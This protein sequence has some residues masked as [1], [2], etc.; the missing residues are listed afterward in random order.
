M[1]P[2]GAPETPSSHDANAPADPD[3]AALPVVVAQ[4]IRRALRSQLS[5]R[6]TGT[7]VPVPHDRPGG[8]RRDDDNQFI[9][10]LGGRQCLVTVDPWLAEPEDAAGGDRK[11]EKSQ[12]PHAPPPVPI[13][14]DPQRPVVHL[15][16]IPEE[17]VLYVQHL[18]VGELA[19]QLGQLD[20]EDALMDL[21]DGKTWSP[22]AND[23]SLTF[24][25]GRV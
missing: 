21:S 6:Q 2:S 4:R 9:V 1:T 25:P 7:P 15:G 12:A 13:P 11:S 14:S 10:E 23:L 16:F 18:S 20:A 19:H 24:D 8:T 17:R 22:S 5:A 3:D